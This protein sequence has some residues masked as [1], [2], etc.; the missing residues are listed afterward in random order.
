MA[1]IERDSIDDRLPTHEASR[2]HG[3]LTGLGPRARGMRH[4]LRLPQ[5]GVTKIVNSI[6][7]VDRAKRTSITSTST[8][9]VDQ[10]RAVENRW[11]SDVAFE[12]F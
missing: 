12:A 3:I 2:R 8:S 7:A 4:T 1:I 5:G 9:N 6:R 11:I 10:A